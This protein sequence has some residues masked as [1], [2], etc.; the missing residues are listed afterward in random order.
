[1]ASFLANAAFSFLCW[2]SFG[3]LC[4]KDLGL[5]LDRTYGGSCKA[6]GRFDN[7]WL[8]SIVLSELTKSSTSDPPTAWVSAD[9]RKRNFQSVV[10]S[11]VQPVVLADFHH[12]AEKTM[13]QSSVVLADFHHMAQNTMALSVDIPERTPELDGASGARTSY[14]QRACLRV[15]VSVSLKLLTAY[16]LNWNQRLRQ[17]CSLGKRRRISSE[18]NVVVVEEVN[19]EGVLGTLDT[20]RT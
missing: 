3:F 18:N 19:V 1:M 13:A 4:L 15:C 20:T 2:F 17:H 7:T 16:N 6:P 12:M 14:R 11:V 10:P 9:V 8:F 5:P